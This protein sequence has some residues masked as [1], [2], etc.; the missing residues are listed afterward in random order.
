M[1]ITIETVGG[2]LI[3]VVSGPDEA[4]S[5]NYIFYSDLPRLISRAKE[6]GAVNGVPGPVF[7]VLVSEHLIHVRK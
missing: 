6:L 1:R 7:A 3:D 4:V 2:N 5:Q